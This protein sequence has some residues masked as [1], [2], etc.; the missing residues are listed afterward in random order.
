MLGRV[1]LG[2]TG[3]AGC[4]K[5]TVAD[6]LV[7]NHGFVRLRFS[8]PLKTMLRSIGLTETHIEG[9]L[10]EMPC[11]LLCG[12]TPRQAMLWLGTEWGRQMIGPDFWVRAW[13]EVLKQLPADRNV[14]VEDC[15]FPNEAAAIHRA[16]QHAAVVHLTRGLSP[17]AAIDHVSE[18]HQLPADFTIDNNS[19]IE[20]LLSQVDLILAQ[21]RA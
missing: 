9:A 13:Q 11:E 15:R 8:A 16:A 10:K 7:F 12:K 4:G 1:V 6:H 18:Q 20:E 2:L 17:V 5:S 21:V 14:I 19:T 3:R